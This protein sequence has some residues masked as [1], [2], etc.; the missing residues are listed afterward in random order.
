M[1]YAISHGRV[2]LLIPELDTVAFLRIIAASY[3]AQLGKKNFE[4]LS[5]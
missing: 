5:H 4:F 1:V 3:E 2:T